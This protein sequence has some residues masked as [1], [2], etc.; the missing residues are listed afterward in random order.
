MR[1]D[2]ENWKEICQQL[3]LNGLSQRTACEKYKLGWQTLKEILSLEEPLG[4]RPEC[5]DYRP[6]PLCI[7]TFAEARRSRA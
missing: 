6:R 2:M 5:E 4:Y 7:Q 1:S 3:L